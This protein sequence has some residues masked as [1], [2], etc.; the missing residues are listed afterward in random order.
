MLENLGHLIW[1]S[2]ASFAMHKV[3]KGQIGF[4]TTGIGAATSLLLKQ[5]LIAKN[6]TKVDWP[7]FMM[8]WMIFCG[9]AISLKHMGTSRS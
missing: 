7:T 8:V 9:E 1:Y 3:C 5:K 4:M 2:D 6:Y